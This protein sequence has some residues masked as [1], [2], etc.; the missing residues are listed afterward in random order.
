M[1]I[2]ILQNKIKIKGEKK[3]T[4]QQKKIVRNIIVSTKDGEGEICLKTSAEINKND[5]IKE[6]NL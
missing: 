5:N 6:K 1:E 2:Y 4:K 3:K